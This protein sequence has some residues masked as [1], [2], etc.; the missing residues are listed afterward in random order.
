M[1]PFCACRNDQ[2][3]I[4]LKRRTL[5]SHIRG[6]CD[7]RTMLSVPFL[8][9]HLL[10]LKSANQ[11]SLKTIFSK[12]IDLEYRPHLLPPSQ[13]NHKLG[14]KTAGISHQF[15]S[16]HDNLEKNVGWRTGSPP[17]IWIRQS[18]FLRPSLTSGKIL[19][20]QIFVCFSVHLCNWKIAQ[21]PAENCC[22]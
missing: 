1:S 13:R 7:V 15:P 21:Q 8:S 16:I 18:G 11:C 19:T 14:T 6:L 17:I 2:H 3:V 10:P 9:Y 20:D 5:I 22:I 12:V 4:S